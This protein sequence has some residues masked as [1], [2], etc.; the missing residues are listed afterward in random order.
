MAQVELA[1]LL[2]EYAF[3]AGALVWGVTHHHSNG[4]TTTAQQ[5]Q[6]SDVPPDEDPGS[7]IAPDDN[8]S[9]EP[10]GGIVPGTEISFVRHAGPHDTYQDLVMLEARRHWSILTRFVGR[11]WRY[12]P[13]MSVGMIIRAARKHHISMEQQYARAYKRAMMALIQQKPIPVSTPLP[14][15]RM[16]AHSNIPGLLALRRGLKRVAGSDPFGTP[17]ATPRFRARQRVA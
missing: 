2:G 13:Y 5:S 14:V 3:A 1:I 9:D 17:P 10:S 8:S 12:I 4:G 16:I 7:G 6:S 15:R 11:Y